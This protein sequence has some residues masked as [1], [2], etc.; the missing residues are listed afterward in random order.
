MIEKV[1]FR[2]FKSLRHV[3]LDLERLTVIVGPNASG[4][5][6]ILNGVQTLAR[7]IMKGVGNV[8]GD[9]ETI[10]LLYTRGG[11]SGPMELEAQGEAGIVRLFV[12]P[13]HVSES[14][15][16]PEL[17]SGSKGEVWLQKL[18]GTSLDAGQGR[19]TE[20]KS[21]NPE[22]FKKL[23]PI[24]SCLRSTRLLRLDPARLAAPSHSALSR[25]EMQSDGEGLASVLAFMALNQPGEFASL[26]SRMKSVIPVIER[27]RFD[28]VAVSRQE[29][30]VLNIDG[31][32]VPR[33]LEKQYIG[34]EIILDF[35]G[36]SNIPAHLASE[37]SLLV[38]GLVTALAGPT[39]PR[40]VLLDDLDHGLHPKAQRKLIEII[41]AI[42][43]DDPQIQ[44]VATTHSP[45]VVDELA[46]EEVRITWAGE[47]GVT[48]CARLDQHPDLERWK[49]EMWPG[50][51]WSLVGEQWVTN[52]RSQEGH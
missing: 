30:E 33:R 51:F 3:D 52:G 27:I 38:L 26:Q 4:K 13:L 21:L 17:H 25:P 12:A 36:A 42:L 16:L 8:L 45:Y 2:N 32:S 43:K 1:S 28:R 24:V 15:T 9:R 39:Q 6:N 44:I 7:S 23:G 5:T 48:T 35:Q 14:P 47:D 31:Q 40:L 49:D 20:L 10:P 46:P 11:Y 50:E 29:I 22:M 34:D 41:R 19:W 37:G 18:E